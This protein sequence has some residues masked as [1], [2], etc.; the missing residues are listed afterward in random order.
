MHDV[1]SPP[2]MYLFLIL[3]FIS[4][5]GICFYFYFWVILVKCFSYLITWC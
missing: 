2:I 3:V 4:F 5:C 1:T